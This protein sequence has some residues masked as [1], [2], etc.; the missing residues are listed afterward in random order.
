MPSEKKFELRIGSRAQ[1]MHGTAK[2]TSGGL[3]KDKLKYNKDGAIVSVE[4]SRQAKKDNRL[5]EYGYTP[6]KGKFT[7]FRKHK[8]TRG[9][10]KLR[11]QKRR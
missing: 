1:V 11:T 4:K 2:M 7:L 9:H 10:R 3:T 8:A 5:T 6:K